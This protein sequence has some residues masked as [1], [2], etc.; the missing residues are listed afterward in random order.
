MEFVLDITC[1]A[2]SFLLLLRPSYYSYV[3]PTTP[4]YFIK[5]AEKRVPAVNGR[6]TDRMNVL[7]P[8]IA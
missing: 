2:K 7:A 6:G 3:L 1:Y 8:Y 4:T 5:Y